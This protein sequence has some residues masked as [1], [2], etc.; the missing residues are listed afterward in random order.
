MIP[1]DMTREA[2]DAEIVAISGYLFRL[3]GDELA[4]TRERLASLCIA[5]GYMSEADARACGAMSEAV[6]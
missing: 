3:R 5:A 6:R 2:I 1:T 4:A